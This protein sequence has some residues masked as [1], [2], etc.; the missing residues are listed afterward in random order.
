MERAADPRF[1]PLESGSV[2]AAQRLVFGV[3]RLDDPSQ[4]G[5]VE[6]KPDLVRKMVDFQLS[7]SILAGDIPGQDIADA[8]TI[9]KLHV[10]E[11]EKYLFPSLN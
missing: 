11:V 2:E 4:A 10:L 7:S 3:E 1:L 8:V 5:V 9:D 6:D